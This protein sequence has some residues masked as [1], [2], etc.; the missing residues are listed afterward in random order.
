MRQFISDTISYMT[1]K[2]TKHHFNVDLDIVSTDKIEK[3]YGPVD[4]ITQ[5][6]LPKQDLMNN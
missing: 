4:P 5:N 3:K 2:H 6:L 1:R